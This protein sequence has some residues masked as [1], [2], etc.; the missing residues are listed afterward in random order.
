ME[1]STLISKL[2]KI[3]ICKQGVLF[4]PTEDEEEFLRQRQE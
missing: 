3:L 4:K 2:T 1:S